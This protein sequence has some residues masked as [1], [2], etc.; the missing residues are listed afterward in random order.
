MMRV[1]KYSSIG[2]GAL[3]SVY[4]F[5]WRIWGTGALLEEGAK[6]IL[7]QGIT[8][9]HLK[10]EFFIASRKNGRLISHRYKIQVPGKVIRTFGS[11]D[12]V[13]TYIAQM[14]RELAGTE[15]MHFY[16]DINVIRNTPYFAIVDSRVYTFEEGLM[17]LRPD[18]T[19]AFTWMIFGWVRLPVSEETR[20]EEQGN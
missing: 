16:L 17:R 1:L 3:F 6:A 5:S 18:D 11:E 8:Q 7:A 15:N 13:K 2:L 19:I 20:V 12:Q 10:D 4:L 9:F 14:E